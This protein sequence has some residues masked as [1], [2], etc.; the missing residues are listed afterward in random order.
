M[1]DFLIR[2]NALVGQKFNKI[3]DAL[4][5]DHINLAFLLGV[6]RFGKV[7]PAPRKSAPVQTA[8]N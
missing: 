6:G 4:V 7:V 5:C 1:L 8:L 2:V 3:H